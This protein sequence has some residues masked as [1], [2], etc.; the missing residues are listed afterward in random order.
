MFVKLEFDDSDIVFNVDN[1]S[2]IQSYGSD[3]GIV[4]NNGKIYDIEKDHYEQL[5][6]ILT[7]KI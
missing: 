7:K 5:C 1:I 4:M 6:K 3:Y 2:S